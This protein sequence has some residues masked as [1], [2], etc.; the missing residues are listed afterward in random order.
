MEMTTR[1]RAAAALDQTHGKT[2]IG[3]R[4]DR[5]RATLASWLDGQIKMKATLARRYV[6]Y[7]EMIARS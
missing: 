6:D 5:V 1:D 4:T 3:I 7:L 2:M